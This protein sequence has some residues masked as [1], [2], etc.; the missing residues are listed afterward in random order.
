MRELIELAGHLVETVKELVALAERLL[1]TW[2]MSVLLVE[3]DGP[4]NVFRR[5]RKWA[6]SLSVPG[7]ESELS[8]ALSCVWCTSVWVG[9]ALTLVQRIWPWPVR[10]LAASAGA[11]II[12]EWLYDDQPAEHYTFE[13]ADWLQEAASV[14]G[15]DGI[16]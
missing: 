2:R 5:L 6:R 13:P 12:Y 7:K 4:Y 11:V 15:D 3:E 8:Q 1:A 9:A 16:H 10:A 14:E